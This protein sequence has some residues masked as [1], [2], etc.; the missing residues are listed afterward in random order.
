MK[1]PYG[2][3]YI[4]DNDIQAVIDVLKGD[5]LTQGPNID[6]FE[7]AFAQYVNA[8]Y[9]IAFN[10]GTSAL[11]GAMFAANV[12]V[13]DE[14][15]TS[16]IT[17]A[18]SA[19]CGVYMGATPVLADIDPKTYCIDPE[20]I[21]KTISQK[22]KAI[23]PVDLAGYPV[24][25]DKIKETTKD[26]DIVIV[27][28]AAHALGA[29]RKGEQIG[30]QADMT[31][32]SFHPVKHITTAEGGMITTNNKEYYEKLKLFRSHGI[33]KDN[34]KLQKIDGPWY[35]EMQTLG[36]NYR[37]TDMQCALGLSQLKKA[38]KFINRR[39][40]LA[41]RYDKAFKDNPLIQTP[42]RPKEHDGRHVFHIYPI[43]LDKSLDRKEIFI[44]LRENGIFCQVHY[45]PI[46]HQPYYQKQFNYQTSQFPKANDYYQR[47]ITIPLFPKMTDE[48]QAYVIEN[49]NKLT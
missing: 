29:T 24:D 18:A 16:P 9:A 43:L 27:E 35:Y 14:I 49:I 10:S 48:E 21:K 23:I 30:T 28:D 26:T 36:Y 40:Q 13:G 41:D 46:H 33:T 7:K 5:W 4:D 44:K 6:T 38:D 20:E 47:E 45:I 22:T 17:F 15:I 1:I 12:T 11:H 2:S 8:K 3:Q 39:I 32:F 25:M 19:N 42:P 34:D 37:I 31:M